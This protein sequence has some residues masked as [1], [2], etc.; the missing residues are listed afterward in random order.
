[1]FLTLASGAAAWANTYEG[2]M[3]AYLANDVS[4][5][6]EDPVLVSAIESQNVN[7]ADL[8]QEEIGQLDQVWQQQIGQRYRPLIDPVLNSP[9]AAFLQQKVQETGGLITEVFIM[10]ARGLNVAAS[11]IPS[12]YW[13][14]DE[15]KF[16]ETFSKGA[17]AVH[18][19]P[20]EFDESS[21]SY[22]GQISTVI[23]DP[24]SGKPIGA[25]TI[26]LNAEMLK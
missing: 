6:I 7:T 16:Q 11:G 15:A 23:V 4:R 19:G 8:S 25:V 5:W 17:G 2:K 18:L 24:A 3:R 22:S 1:M 12:D 9:A 10:D 20:V 14:G 26:G 13:Q 21:Q